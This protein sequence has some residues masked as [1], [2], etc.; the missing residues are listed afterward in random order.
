MKKVRYLLL[1]GLTLLPFAH[2]AP[3][4]ED[5]PEGQ[6]Y[7]YNAE[8][9]RRGEIE[10]H[11]PEGHD[12][13]TDRVPGI[14]LFHG[15]GWRRGDRSQFRALSHYFASRGLVATTAHYKLADRDALGNRTANP[16]P[17]RAC[18]TSAK[19]AI[20]W[21]KQNADE[22]GIDPDRIIGGGG[23]AGAHV[24]LLATLNP[25]LN[26][27]ADPADIDTS[28]VA[29]VLFNPAFQPGSDRHDPEVNIEEHLHVDMAPMVVF[30]GSND[31]W[32]G[33][34]DQT[35]N[36]MKALGIDSKLT[37]WTAVGEGH[38]FFN[39]EPWKSLTMI[40]ADRFL[41]RQGLLQGNPTI[42][43]PDSGKSLVRGPQPATSQ[44]EADDDL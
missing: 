1:P 34:W 11:F 38:A 19:S 3:L 30:W 42:T 43:A 27:P 28:V 12:P 10:I 7:V 40:E 9:G 24:L 22:L 32:L 37:W 29:Y 44:T 25:G 20:R 8:Y 23:S 36:R 17:K 15:G 39:D 4:P 13:A 2:S 33:G 14:I 16:S 5:V 31:N 18:I 26:D 41:V 21:L 35:F 6:V